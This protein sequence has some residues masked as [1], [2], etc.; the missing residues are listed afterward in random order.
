MCMYNV[1]MYV[2]H[3]RGT[4]NLKKKHKICYY[5]ENQYNTAIK[6]IHNKHTELM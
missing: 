6:D 5:N 1:N 4:R 3:G 2:Y